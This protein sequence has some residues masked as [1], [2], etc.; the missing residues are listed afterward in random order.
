MFV[1][2]LTLFM[3]IPALIIVGLILAFYLVTV[4]QARKRGYSWWV[5]LPATICSNPLWTLIV[6]GILPHQARRRLRKKFEAELDAKLKESNSV[7]ETVDAL[8]VPTH[9]LGDV[10][11]MLPPDASTADA[12]RYSPGRSLGD[13]ETTG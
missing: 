2:P 6:L 8:S 12:P 13:Q 11:T 9:S 1:D 3:I 5:W 4:L 7:A 10:A